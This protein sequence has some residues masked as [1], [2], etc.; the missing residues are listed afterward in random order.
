MFTFPPSVPNTILK[1]IEPVKKYAIFGDEYEQKS[2]AIEILQEIKKRTM[3]K[4]VS[5]QYESAFKLMTRTWDI[6]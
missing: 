2:Q 4:M 1:M 3:F 5:S 6:R